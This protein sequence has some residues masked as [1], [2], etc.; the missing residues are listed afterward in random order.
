MCN[1]VKV[2]LTAAHPYFLT[3]KSSTYNIVQ[4]FITAAHPYFFG[5]VQST[6]PWEMLFF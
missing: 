5:K 3:N 6:L 2:F 1:I 4:V